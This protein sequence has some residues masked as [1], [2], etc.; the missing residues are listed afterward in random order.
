MLDLDEDLPAATA[1]TAV[2][3]RLLSDQLL[4]VIVGPTASGKTQLALRIAEAIGAEIVGC[5]ALQ[6]RSGLPILTAKPRAED[7]A[8]VSHHLI[9]ILPAQPAASAAQYV[10]LADDVLA[11]LAQRRCPAVLCG[12]TGLYLRAL[13]EGLFPG[14]AADPHLRAALRQE[15]AEH[16]WPH[17]HA[18][19]AQIDPAAAARIRPTDPVRIERAIEI[20]AQSQKTQSQWFAEHAA[21]RARGPRYRTLRIALDP[22][23]DVGRARIASRSQQMFSDGVLDEVAAQRAQGPLADAPLGYDLLCQVLDGALS[24]DACQTQLVQQTAHYARRQRTWL[25]REPDLTWYPDL[26]AVPIE[27]IVRAVQAASAAA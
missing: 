9:G 3:P 23:P 18:R 17:V 27:P 24:V 2:G 16:G 6:I 5:D 10:A 13:C 4:V 25:R 22:G 1:P 14:P 7:I 20:F 19:L 8:R 12:G 15:A 26:D 21:E 11:R